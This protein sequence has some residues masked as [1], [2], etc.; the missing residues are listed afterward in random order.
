MGTV[1]LFID[2]LIIDVQKLYCTAFLY[3]GQFQRPY[4]KCCTNKAAGSGLQIFPVYQMVGVVTAEMN[5][6]R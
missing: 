5:N 4:G 6:L 1:T 2:F 3:F